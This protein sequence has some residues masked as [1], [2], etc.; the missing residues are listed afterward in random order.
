MKNNKEI[1]VF[2]LYLP[3]ENEKIKLK[4]FC[5]EIEEICNKY[6]E[7]DIIIAGDLNLEYDKFSKCLKKIINIFQLEKILTGPTHKNKE[8]DHILTS[9]RLNSK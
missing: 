9:K 2:G 5:I 8:I 1:L 4:Q 3:N 6:N 7:P